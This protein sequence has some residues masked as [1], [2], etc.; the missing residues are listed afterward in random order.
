MCYVDARIFM[1][2]AKGA[3]FCSDYGAQLLHLKN[4]DFNNMIKGKILPN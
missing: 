3:A 1:T 4:A 2:R